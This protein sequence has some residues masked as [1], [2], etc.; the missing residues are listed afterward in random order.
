MI[1]AP[2]H[3]IRAC[4]IQEHAQ[5]PG[6]RSRC[7]RGRVE[8]SFRFAAHEFVGHSGRR[9]TPQRY[10]PVAVVVVVEVAQRSLITYEEAR[11]TVTRSLV[12]FR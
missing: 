5:P 1:S 10:A 3:L 11:F 6:E 4:R 12:H 9:G 7:G 2:P 8:E